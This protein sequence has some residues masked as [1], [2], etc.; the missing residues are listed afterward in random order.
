MSNRRRVKE[1]ETELKIVH[2][3]LWCRSKRG[4]FHARHGK[5]FSKY[6]DIIRELENISIKWKIKKF[7]RRLKLWLK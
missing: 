3:E 5:K 1:L 6:V 2:A 7:F 4:R